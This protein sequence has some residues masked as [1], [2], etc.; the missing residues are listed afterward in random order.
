[1][2][3]CGAATK[4]HTTHLATSGGYYLH[5]ETGAASCRLSYYNA[6]TIVDDEIVGSVAVKEWWLGLGL[7]GEA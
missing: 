5:R 2:A 4:A 6:P 7:G 1:M 3:L